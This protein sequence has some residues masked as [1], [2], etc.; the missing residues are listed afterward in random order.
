MSRLVALHTGGSREPWQ[1]LGLIFE[2]DTCSLADVDLV[3]SDQA[4]G[5]FHW[6]ISGEHDEI[7]NIDGISTQIVSTPS[8][9]SADSLIGTQRMTHL[10]HVVV[11]TDNLDRTC[12][13]IDAALGAEMRREREV[14]NGVVQRFHKLENTI[15]EVVT[16]PHITTEGA[17]LWG[18]VVS[19]DDLFELADQVGDQVMSPPKRATQ[20]GRYI[21]T[22]RGSVGLGVPF[23]LMT[24]HVAGMA[25]H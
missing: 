1:S 22:V 16:G 23:A 13:A 20:P 7:L 2:N 14:G 24:P 17:S 6:V 12:A 11:N 15:I 18:M 3:V 19:V 9:R 5:L 4:P 8:T 25:T 10:D 21:S